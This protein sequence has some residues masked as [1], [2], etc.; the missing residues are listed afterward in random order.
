MYCQTKMI[1]RR[2][3][4]RD[5]KIWFN[6]LPSCILLFVWLKPP[7]RYSSCKN[8]TAAGK[9]LVIEPRYDKINKMSMR[10]TKTL[11]NPGIR[12]V[13]AEFSLCAQWVAKDPV[14]LH[15]HSED[16]SD[17]VDAQADLSLC[18]AQTHFVG[19]VMS[20]LILVW[21]KLPDWHSSCPLDLWL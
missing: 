7:E 17:W 11:I 10:P 20:R 18:W 6:Y 14:F 16:W 13:W 1:L 15:A 12:P 9:T 19:F 2:E 21:L 3:R 5:K 8:R 4:E